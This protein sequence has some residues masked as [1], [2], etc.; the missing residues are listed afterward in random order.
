[1]LFTPWTAYGFRFA[2]FG[3][4]DIGTLGPDADS[5]LD[6]K[7][8]SMVGLGIRLHNDRLVFEPTEM[9]FSVAVSPPPGAS[10]KI[11]GFGSMSTTPLPRLDPGAPALIP[12]R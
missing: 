5:F 9:R 7:Y 10:T 4:L 3:K 11:F 2:F 6:G 1:M 8:Y 12:Y